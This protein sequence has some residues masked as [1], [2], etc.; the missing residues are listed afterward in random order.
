MLTDLESCVVDLLSPSK[1]SSSFTI[2]AL[3]IRGL[4]RVVLISGYI[5]GSVFLH[6]C[7]ECTLVLGCQ[8]VSLIL[9]L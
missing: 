7:E 2:N 1:E 3:H 4:K 8:Q 9:S 6:D 5:N